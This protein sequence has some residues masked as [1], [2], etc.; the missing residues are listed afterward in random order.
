[1]ASPHSNPLASPPLRKNYQKSTV[2]SEMRMALTTGRTPPP[3]KPPRPKSMGLTP[4][5]SH[6]S[7]PTRRRPLSGTPMAMATPPASHTSS[8]TRRP[9]LSGTPKH[10]ISP[11][12]VENRE[13]Q[14]PGKVPTPGFAPNGA[15]R[16][17]LGPAFASEASVAAEEAEA[18]FANELVHAVSSTFE[19]SVAA[20]EAEAAFANELVQ[21]SEASIAAKEAEA[22]FANVLV[23]A[24][25]STLE[26]DVDVAAAVSEAV[27]RAM[28]ELMEAHD[29]AMA[30]E[31]EPAPPADLALESPRAPTEFALV[32]QEAPAPISP[33]LFTLL[34]VEQTT[35]QLHF[36]PPPA[37]APKRS[38]LS[39]RMALAAMAVGA[40][41]LAGMRHILFVLYLRYQL[42][43]FG[44]TRT[45]YIP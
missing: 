18:A 36:C 35:S 9:P 13:I 11:F 19:D 42:R 33:E 27:Q 10:I 30:D 26:D 14:S 45:I 38:G 41:A 2:C 34:V 28:L 3:P 39:A 8:P 24:V 1:M 43:G 17:A 20:K 6:T 22:A 29:A 23:Q 4:P 44:L 31:I 21:A 40:I 37:A 12:T 5:A 15:R 25:S 16:V 32:E 7:S